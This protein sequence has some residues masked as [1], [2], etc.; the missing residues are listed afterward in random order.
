MRQKVLIVGGRNKAKTLSQ[1]LIRQGYRVTIVNN[2]YSDCEKLAEN[3]KLK[4]FCGDGTDPYILEEADAAGM[5]IAVAL[6]PKDAANL[7]ICQLCRKKFKIPKTVSLL[8]D[9]NKLD[10]FYKMGIDDVICVAK[11]VFEHIDG[12]QYENGRK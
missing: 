3:S 11:D 4:V 6:T 10:F 8:S 5:D 1:L 7:V 9:L 2:D 12:Q